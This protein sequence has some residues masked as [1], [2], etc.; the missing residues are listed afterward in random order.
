MQTSAALRLKRYVMVMVL[1]MSTICAFSQSMS[2]E[3]VVQFVKTE[4]SKGS[5][6]STI[7]TKLLQKG[8]TAEQLRRVRKKYTA[9][10]QQLGAQD[11]TGSTKTEGTSRL[12]TE[13]QVNDDKRQ[14]QQNYMIRSQ[15]EAQEQRYLPRETRQEALGDEIGFL[16]IDSIAYY[17]QL[18]QAQNE[19]EVFGR[20]IFNNRNL[21]FQPN[22]NMATPANYKLGAGDKVIIDIWGASQKTFENTISPDG[23]IVLDRIG[24]I[25][26]MGLSVQ[27]ADKKI[28]NTLSRYYAD[29]NFSVSLGETRTIQVQVMG[30]VNVPGTYTMSSL[31][32]AFNALYAAGGINSIGTLRNIKVYRQNRVVAVI[33]VY[34]MLL[35]GNTSGDIRLNDNDVI[36]VGAYDCIVCVRGK[37]KRPM[38]YEMKNS[39]SVRQLIKYAGGFTGDAYK[40]NLKLV[41]TDGE[42]RSIHTIDEFQMSSFSVRDHDS[43]HVDSVLPRFS[44]MVEVRG[45][46]N[47]PG[48]F[49]LSRDIQTVRGLLQAAGGIREDAYRTRVVMHREKED[50]T[51]QM[52]SIDLEGILNGTVAD[53]PLKK[54]DVLFIPSTVEMQGETTLTISGEVLYPGIYQYAENTTLGDLILQAGGFTNSASLAKVDVFRR[55]RDPKALENNN[56]A[57]ETYS[58]ALDERLNILSDTTFF[59]LPYDEVVIRKS[60]AY[61]E[62]QNVKIRGCVNFEG[63]Y[64]MSTK[65]Y[66]L[67]DLVK[68]AGGLSAL[69]YSKGARLNRQMTEEERQQREVM[70]RTSQIEMYEEALQG[71]KNF[72][73]SRAD[74]LMQMRVDMGNRYAVAINLEEAINNPGGQEDIVLRENDE[75]IIPQ[76]SST[77]KISGAVMHPI[78]MN[79]REGENLSYYIKHAGGYSNKAHKSRVYAT[80]M[81][82]SVKK[83]SRKSVRDIEPGCEIVVP[84]KQS[85]K[86]M[87]TAEIMTLGTST[88]SIATMVVT[89][90]NILKK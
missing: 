42:E 81:N 21:T 37:V 72:D 76:Y 40:G 24:P 6:Q 63:E 89:L 68:A 80:Y 50:L 15:R 82:G 87:S 1:M 60:P 53:V 9:E 4:M 35:N 11:L 47:R 13:K 29:C 79:Y 27:Q 46:V 32:S 84:T 22:Q 41:R 73:L 14:Q 55:I 18:I 39:E 86:K 69:A 28:K 5:T 33:D 64:A 57:S 48:Q 26:L 62:Q 25:Q 74:T 44:N 78:S 12:R 59:L 36:V 66:R 77:I 34:D 30:E 61:Q 75:L 56:A 71:D 45:A 10:Q 65:S 49:Q 2:D 17:Q 20:N 43:L 8:V 51:L 88:I 58:F 7:V 31:S 85:G 83:I 90:L 23:A 52:V 19:N 67:S 16:D 54:N 3:Q 38:Y 70:L